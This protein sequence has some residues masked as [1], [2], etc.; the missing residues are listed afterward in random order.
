MIKIIE[1]PR[2]AMQGLHEFIPTADKIRYLNSLLKVGF[3]SIDFGSFV[4]PKAVPQMRDTA[5]VLENLD[6]ISTK[7]QLLC[8][9]A[10]ENGAKNAMQ[11]PQIQYV[12]FP[13]SVSE[14]FQMRNTNKTIEQ[15]WQ[16]LQNIQND[17]IIHSKQLIVYLSMAFGNPYGEDF[18]EEMIDEFV[19]KLAKIGIKIILLSDT[20][21]VSQAAQIDRMFKN[22]FSKFDLEIGAHF[23]SNPRTAVEKIRAAHLA[24]CIRFDTAVEGYGGC[25]FAKEELTGNIDTQTLI[26]Y[27]AEKQIDTSLKMPEFA[28]A[29]KIC[30]D[31]FPKR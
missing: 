19:E 4:S 11:Y 27:F 28:Q 2:D 7:S 20:I 9:I 22:L 6:L 12:G 18:S 1:C 8:V 25:P 29:V 16:A 23:H 14:T 3:D 31:I 30:R 21:G 24:G 17:C 10:N 15:A 5:E 13:L 26:S